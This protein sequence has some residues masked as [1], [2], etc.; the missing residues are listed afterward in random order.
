[1]AGKQVVTELEVLFTADTSAVDKAGK[2]VKTAAEAIEKKPIEATV[3][4]DP[5]DALAGMER[6]EQAAKKIVSADTVARVDANIGRAEKDL[7]RIEKNLEYLHSVETELDVSAQVSKAEKDLKRI[8]RQRDGLVAARATME[9]VADT[10]K[11]EAALDDVKKPAAKAGDDAG[12]AFGGKILD[13]IGSIPV[14]GAVAVIGAGAAAALLAAFNDGLQQEKGRDR[15]QALTGIDEAEARRLANAAGEAYA[16]TFGESIEANM[17]TARIATQY[18]LIDPAGTTR[19][20]QKVIQGLAGIADVLGEDVA[21]VSRAVSQMLRT[22]LV[23]SADQAFDVLATGAREG[24]NASED[25]LDTFIEYGTHF[26]DLGLSADEALGL[27]NQG[28]DG[29]AFNADKV[30]DSMKSLTTRVKAGGKDSAGALKELGLDAGGVRDAFNSGGVAA[31]EAFDSILTGLQD[32]EEPVDRNRLA[33]ALFGTQAEDMAQALGS[34]DLSTAVEQLNGVE[35]AAKKML[36]TITDNDATKME[37]ARRNIEVAADGMKGALAVAFSEPLGDLADWVTENRGP[38]LEFFT[39]L[40]NG[41]FDFA[42]GASQATG[43]FVSGPLAAMIEGLAAVAG[44]FGDGPPQELVDL[45]ADMRGFS[46]TT[47]DATAR[48]EGWRAQFN[49]F[50]DEQI[51]LGHVHDAAK[52]TAGAVDD[53]GIASDGSKMELDDL[54]ASNLA[55]S[56]AGRRLDE[57]LQTAAG[58][59]EAELRAAAA[60]GESQENLAE[61]YLTT[62]DALREQ[63]EAMGVT[64]DEAE[65]LIATYLGVPGQVSTYM[66]APG[67]DVAR[68]MVAALHAEIDDLPKKKQSEI[69]AALNEGDIDTVLEALGR[70]PSEKHVTI[71]AEMA[72]AAGPAGGFRLLRENAKGGLLEFMAGG[73]LRGHGLTPMQPVAQMVPP[74]TWRVVGDRGDVTELYAP[75]D[76]SMRSW[77]LLLEGLRRMPGVPPQMMADGGLIGHTNP[78]ADHAMVSPAIHIENHGVDAAELAARTEAQLEHWMRSIATSRR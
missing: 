39:D 41:A 59:L 33:I 54:T 55:A 73:G 48:M 18:K 76:G 44:Y 65:D 1:M 74:S 31:R 30:A 50:A 68:E 35:G 14:A 40:V 47:D 69:R 4:A 32:V 2:T 34:L 36:D 11:A 22:G 53:L 58:N 61:R 60:A 17:D 78:S 66:D 72:E 71:T 56:E 52:R 5:A 10:S 28:L 77:M 38:L 45:A 29:G 16:S 43:E 6:V 12:K 51:A 62:R 7:A 3:T 46:K 24:V 75:L 57:Q 15:L 27:L 70:V 67:T 64:R 9:I 8:Q 26:R 20:S 25:L 37:K 19:D 13:A 49:G 23:K 21:P 63:L 42:I